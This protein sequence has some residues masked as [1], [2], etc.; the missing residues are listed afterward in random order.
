MSKKSPNT[1]FDTF[2]TLFWAL[3]FFDTFLATPAWE[4]REYLFETFGG[5]L[6]MAVPTAKLVHVALLPKKVISITASKHGRTKSR[7]NSTSSCITTVWLSCRAGVAGCGI[8]ENPLQQSSELCF[9]SRLE[10][11]KLE[12]ARPWYNAEIPELPLDR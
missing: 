3:D 6:Y 1:D 8:A 12:T 2:L 11:P 7:S 5:L 4:V 10:D 9:G